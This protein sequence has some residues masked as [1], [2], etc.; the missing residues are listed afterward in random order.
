MNDDRD[1]LSEEKLFL[2]AAEMGL[3]LLE[4]H[5]SL[6]KRAT[7]NAAQEAKTIQDLSLLT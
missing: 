5:Q 3:V 2:L 7:N 1:P 4:D 6:E